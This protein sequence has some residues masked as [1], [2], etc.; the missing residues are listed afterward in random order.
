MQIHIHVME[1][2]G[3]ITIYRWH[4]GM[5][6]ANVGFV[7]NMDAFHLR[8]RLH[9][10]PCLSYQRFEHTLPTYLFPTLFDPVK[11]LVLTE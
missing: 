8:V 11:F 10:L 7:V 9:I 6:K 5:Y 1:L 2:P 4:Q 3:L